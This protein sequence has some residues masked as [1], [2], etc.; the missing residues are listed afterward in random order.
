MMGPVS[1][2]NL[3]LVTFS[4]PTPPVCMPEGL[5]PGRRGTGDLSCPSPSV[6]R[7]STRGSPPPSA[8]VR[9]CPGGAG[10]VS[11]AQK[12]HAG[13]HRPL[14]VQR[15][16]GWRWP[17][18]WAGTASLSPVGRAR[19]PGCPAPRRPRRSPAR[20]ASGR[21]HYAACG[22]NRSTR[23]APRSAQP[24]HKLCC[25]LRAASLAGATPSHSTPSSRELCCEL[26]QHNSLSES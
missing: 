21:A 26:S 16:K 24:L 22:D 12:M 10:G 3:P 17:S 14:G 1:E 23:D 8:R 6:S 19:A 5:A 11:L 13:P 25:A 9:G 4:F 15:Y 2:N 7:R 20:T 18:F